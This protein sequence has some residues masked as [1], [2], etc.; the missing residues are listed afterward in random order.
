MDERL[1]DPDI[2][3]LEGISHS[4]PRRKAYSYSQQ[5]R[6]TT[7]SHHK[8]YQNHPRNY[9]LDEIDIFSS[10]PRKNAFYDGNINSSDDE[11]Y[12][13]YSG[14]NSGVGGASDH[15]VDFQGV[16][17]GDAGEFDESQ[18]LPNQP[19]PEFMGSGGG[20]GVFKVPNRAAMHPNRPP[21][22]ELRP[23]PLRETQVGFHGVF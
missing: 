23:H 21:C 19:L 14:T 22:L 3:A 1:K 8:R 10:H 2:A 9:S 16:G 11:D 20:V 6:T 17:M 5:L 12:Y 7:G 18:Q 15:H 4:P 13:R